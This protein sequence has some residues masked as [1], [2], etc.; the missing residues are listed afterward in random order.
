MWSYSYLYKEELLVFHE[1]FEKLVCH[2][3]FLMKTLLSDGESHE[4]HDAT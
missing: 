1:N 3:N 4:E 2:V